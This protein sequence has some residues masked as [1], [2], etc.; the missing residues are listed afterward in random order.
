MPKKTS[1]RGAA[2]T[3]VE[4]RF[5]MLNVRIVKPISEGRWERMHSMHL[6]VYVNK[7]QT[8]ESLC[9]SFTTLHCTKAPFG[10]PSLPV[11]VRE[12]KLDCISEAQI[13]FMDILWIFRHLQGEKW[14]TF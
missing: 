13:S 4:K 1:G 14:W 5:L 12:T 10:D 2:Y 6:S 8:V 7:N 11:K 9:Q 3:S